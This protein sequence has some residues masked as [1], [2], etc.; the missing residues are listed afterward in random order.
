MA[1]HALDLTR[2]WQKNE[3]ISPLYSR[4]LSSSDPLRSRQ[5]I[6]LAQNE[7]PHHQQQQCLLSTAFILS[8]LNQ[9]AMQSI[10]RDRK[11]S[12]QPNAYTATPLPP[13]GWS[14]PWKYSSIFYIATHASHDSIHITSAISSYCPNATATTQQWRY[15]CH[16]AMTLRYH[17][18][19][20]SSSNNEL[21]PTY[22]YQPTRSL[23]ITV[24]PN[25]H[26]K[27]IAM[28]GMV[29]ILSCGYAVEDDGW[30]WEDG[31]SEIFGSYLVPACLEHVCSD[32][33]S[34]GQFGDQF[35]GSKLSSAHLAKLRGLTIKPHLQLFQQ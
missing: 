6:A 28:N 9:S 1:S 5:I 34:G 35:N 17:H 15:H 10:R 26:W 4:L 31:H 13:T 7:G 21:L 30:I 29:R 8:A 23:T 3:N 11:P 27:C 32:N 12:H 19:S 14:H 22:F 25:N 20:S 18:R 33:T 16:H 24:P 2:P